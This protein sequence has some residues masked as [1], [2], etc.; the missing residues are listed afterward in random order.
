MNTSKS[1]PK[2]NGDNI[3]SFQTNTSKLYNEDIFNIGKDQHNIKTT[4][5]YI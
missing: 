4:G 5:H 2:Y 1:F 3:K